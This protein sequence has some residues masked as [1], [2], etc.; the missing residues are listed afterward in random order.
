MPLVL[1]VSG[2]SNT[3]QISHGPDIAPL[4]A[5]LAA[6]VAVVAEPEA[7]DAELAEVEA[8]LAEAEADKEASADFAVE[9]VSDAPAA[10]ASEAARVT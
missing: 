9:I 3:T 4:A 6:L 1:P 2:T 8:E 7:D 10:A 5:T